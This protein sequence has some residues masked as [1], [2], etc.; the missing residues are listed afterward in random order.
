MRV[1]PEARERELGHVGPPDG[2]E[3]G[4]FQAGD[5]NGVAPRRQ[6]IAEDDRAGRGDVAGDVEQVLDRHR[7]AGETR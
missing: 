2:N 4:G 1:D 7:D 5:G 3:A 6:R